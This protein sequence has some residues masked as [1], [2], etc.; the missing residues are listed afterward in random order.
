MPKLRRGAGPTPAE[1]EALL[2]RHPDIREACIISTPDPRRGESVKACVVLEA[3]ASAKPP[4]ADADKKWAE[5]IK[6]RPGLLEK[7]DKDYEDPGPLY[8]VVAFLDEAGTWRVCVD[9]SESGALGEGTL[10]AP[11]RLEHKCGTLDALS[12]LNWLPL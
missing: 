12:L 10:L 4:G 9:T 2:Y 6:A 3:E 8:D 1:V 7:L 11:Y 5:E